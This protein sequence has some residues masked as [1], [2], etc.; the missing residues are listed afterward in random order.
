MT[1][2]GAR[3]TEARKAVKAILASTV[4]VEERAD[5]DC[6]HGA[7]GTAGF[8]GIGNDTLDGGEAIPLASL[9]L[10]PEAGMR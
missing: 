8:R 3:P 10:T 9:G 1:R 2:N 7:D 4:R 5:D 6:G